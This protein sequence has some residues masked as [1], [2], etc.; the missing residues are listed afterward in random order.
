MK[1]K[2]LFVIIVLSLVFVPL[3]YASSCVFAWKDDDITDNLSVYDADYPICMVDIKASTEHFIFT[4][5]GCHDGYCVTGIG[6]LSGVATLESMTRD[7]I[8]HD[9]SNVS[10]YIN[11]DPTP[12][13]ITSF[14]PLSWLAR[15]FRF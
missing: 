14:R 5:D 7:C 10:W 8:V 11:D 1:P 3:V 6:T 15:L 2:L 12:V 9:I 4:E 13:H